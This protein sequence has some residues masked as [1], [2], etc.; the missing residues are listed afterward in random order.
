MGFL[1][2]VCVG[3]NCLQCLYGCSVAIKWFFIVPILALYFG[4]GQ[5]LRMC[6]PNRIMTSFINRD[7]L[8]KNYQFCCWL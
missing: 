2:G 5:V 8:D 3:L 1:K 4:F 6:G 7:F